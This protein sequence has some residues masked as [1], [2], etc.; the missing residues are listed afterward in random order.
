MMIRERIVVAISEAVNLKCDSCCA[1]ADLS[2]RQLAE[3]DEAVMFH[4]DEFQAEYREDGVRCHVTW[5]TIRALPDHQS[6]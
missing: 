1:S 6:M 3:C 5:A 2:Y 4:I